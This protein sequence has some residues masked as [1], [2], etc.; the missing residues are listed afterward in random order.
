MVKVANIHAYLMSVRTSNTCIILEAMS[1]IIVEW[2]NVKKF[3]ESDTIVSNIT[4][5]II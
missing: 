5:A 4:I 3:P 1:E 2:D